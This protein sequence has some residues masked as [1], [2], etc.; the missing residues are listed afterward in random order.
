MNQENIQYWLNKGKWTAEQASFLLLDIDPRN[1]NVQIFLEK[2]DRGDLVELDFFL[3]SLSARFRNKLIK[4]GEILSN[5]QQRMR[6]EAVLNGVGCSDHLPVYFF[7][8]IKI[9]NPFRE[10][11]FSEIEI[12]IEAFKQFAKE[13]IYPENKEYAD[14][15]IFG[16]FHSMDDNN[17]LPTDI[18]QISQENDRHT[19]DNQ[20][21]ELPTIEV[22]NQL[23]HAA[24]VLF[25]KYFAPNSS[26][27]APRLAILPEILK[28]V[29]AKGI[30]INDGK[31]F[32]FCE[33]RELTDAELKT[34]AEI[35]YRE[36]F[37]N[38]IPKTLLK[39]YADILKKQP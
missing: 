2:Q 6:E 15:P 36:I 37:K 29:E 26:D 4:R 28:R 35:V 9:R 23:N 32:A 13:E 10:K 25:N 19:K 30:S 20:V 7:N 18:S 31:K 14:I 11:T 38:E 12:P 39:A 5:I 16:L 1:S 17:D 3:N 24:E 33:S 27:Y 22:V 21:S 8:G 34:Q